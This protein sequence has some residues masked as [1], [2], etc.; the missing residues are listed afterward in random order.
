M[1]AN[2]T[3]TCKRCLNF[4]FADIYKNKFSKLIYSLDQIDLGN[5]KAENMLRGL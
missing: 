4:E 1:L 3:F 2:D 5:N